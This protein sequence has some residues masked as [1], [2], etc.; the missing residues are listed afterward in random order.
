MAT[1]IFSIAPG[2]NGRNALFC[3][4]GANNAEIVAD[5]D[6]MQV[7][8]GEDMNNDLAADRY[9]RPSTPGLDITRVVSVRIALLF[10]SPTESKTLP[11]AAG[12]T[13]TLNDVAVGPYTA[14]RRLRR[15]VT[16][17][18]NLRNRTP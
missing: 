10:Q 13:Y 1:N 7:L 3:N 4:N 18:I 16:T 6:N 9:V 14:D 5:I 11:D 15:E 12:R 2:Q 17:T 8:F